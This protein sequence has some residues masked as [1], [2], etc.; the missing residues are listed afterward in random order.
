MLHLLNFC[1]AIWGKE[2][3]PFFKKYRSGLLS[4][5]CCRLSAWLE[6]KK[7]NKKGGSLT[8]AG[9]GGSG[10]ADPVSPGWEGKLKKRDGFVCLTMSEC[11]GEDGGRGDWRRESLKSRSAREWEKSVTCFR[12]MAS[13]PPTLHGRH[14]SSAAANRGLDMIFS[15][16]VSSARPLSLIFAC[17]ESWSRMLHTEC[18]WHADL[19]WVQ[20]QVCAFFFFL[21]WRFCQD[22]L[23]FLIRFLTPLL[24]TSMITKATSCQ[25]FK[26]TDLILLHYIHHSY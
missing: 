10:W 11:V 7:K 8:P 2:K 23:A 14:G 25:G 19:W 3:C 5:C 26:K 9:D 16:A 4:L 18:S 17:L 12:P 6:V 24:S 20:I 21:G 13:Q 1:S 15:S 22:V